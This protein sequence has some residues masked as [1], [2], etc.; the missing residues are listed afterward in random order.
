M[1]EGERG[2]GEAIQ[3]LGTEL[4]KGKK[5]QGVMQDVFQEGQVVRCGLPVEHSEGRDR[6]GVWKG[7][8]SQRLQM[9]SLHK[10][11]T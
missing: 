10:S 1:I 9:C 4:Q 11:V 5:S 3:A 7:G 8:C 2:D 6:R